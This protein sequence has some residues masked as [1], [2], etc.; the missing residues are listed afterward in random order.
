MEYTKICVRCKVTFLTRKQDKKYCARA[1]YF[2]SKSDMSVTRQCEICDKEFTTPYRFRAVRTCG[3]KCNGV[4]ISRSQR[5][6]EVKQCLACHKDYEAVQSYKEHAKYCSYACFLSTR[7]TQQPD[8]TLICEGCE[9]Q[10]IVPFTKNNRRFCSKSCANTGEN[11]SMFGKVSPRTGKPAWNRGLTAKTDER[12]RALGEKISIRSKEQFKNGERSNASSKN[13][14]YGNTSDTLT[15]EK[16]RHFSEAAIKRVLDGVSGFKTGHVTGVYQSIKSSMPIRFKSSWELA[17]MMWWDLDSTV[18]HYAYE[19]E[20]IELADGRRAIP[21]FWVNYVNNHSEF[22]EIKP[23]LIQRL[24][25]VSEKLRLVYEALESKGITY[26]L[27]GDD[28]IKPMIIKLGKAYIDAIDGY[29]S[30]K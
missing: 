13:P 25:A 5:T 12:V 1:C 17:A 20:I 8:V 22:I 10:F 14:N 15:S 6:R 9:Q 26:R 4:R 11:N 16:R 23:T 7:K 21:D 19:P 27:M 24:P 28:Q 18:L 30:G 3:S 2:A 29:K